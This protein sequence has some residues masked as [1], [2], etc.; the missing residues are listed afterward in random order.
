MLQQFERDSDEPVVRI[1]AQHPVSSWLI[2]AA[3]ALAV[4]V[5]IEFEAP[6][7]VGQGDTVHVIHAVRSPHGQVVVYATATETWSSDGMSEV[8]V[9]PVQFDAEQQA[10]AIR[11]MDA[12]LVVGAACVRFA[13]GEE[14]DLELGPALAAAW[15][16]DACVT[17]VFENHV[18]AVL[19]LPL[20]SP[21]LRGPAAMSAVA[22]A[23]GLHDALRHCFARDRE[24]HVTLYGATGAPG[25]RIGHVT[26]VA[27]EAAD[28]VRRV[29]HAAQY[30]T[31]LIEE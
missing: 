9:E 7:V 28:A 18:R 26:V 31:G 21:Q 19:D 22:Y 27:D 3:D 15:T 8:V 12:A 30:L 2:A 4:H 1:A 5:E 25:M 14:P 24:L 10:A 29:R 17:S 16:I 13:A 11:L 6:A 23:P 20:G